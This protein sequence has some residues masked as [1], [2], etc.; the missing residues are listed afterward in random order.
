MS[1]ADEAGAAPGRLP[2]TGRSGYDALMSTFQPQPFGKYVLVDHIATGG[3]A[4]IFKAKSYSHGGFES[5]LVIKRI[6]PHIG[7]KADFVE[8]FIDEAKI[9]VALQHPNIVRIF[10]FGKLAV[11]DAGGRLLDHYFIAME[12][13]EGK[14]V[15]QLLRQNARR[16]GYIPDRFAAYIALETCKGLHYAHTKCDLD[17][18]PYGVVHRDIS[19]SNVLLSYEGE[20]KVA[21]F[22]IA[23]AESNAYETRD[24][25]LKGKFEYMSPEQAT[26][27]EV[28]GRSDVFSLGIVLYEVL[29]SRRLF[30]TDS[31]LE[32]LKLIRDQDV[33]PPSRLRA[34]VSPQLEAIALRALQRDRNQRYPSAQ[35]MADDLREYLFPATNDQLKAELAA[36]LQEMF[37]AEIVAERARLRVAAGV[38]ASLRDRTSGEWDGNTQ[39][40]L[41]QGAKT[42]VTLVVPTVAGGAMVAALLL[43]VGGAGLWWFRDDL[44]AAVAPVATTGGIDALVVPDAVF[45]V[46]G[47]ERGRGA[48]LSVE[49]LSPG[50]HA[51][52]FEAEGHIGVQR[53]VIVA[54]GE[55]VRLTERLEPV[56]A[57]PTDPVAGGQA[58]GGQPSQPAGGQPAGGQ[59]AAPNTAGNP[60]G[61]Q[62]DADEP[63]RLVLRS[64]PEGAEVFVDGRSVGTSPARFVAEPGKRY[65][66]EMRLEGHQTA[67]ASVSPLEP[68]E[69]ETVSLTLAAAAAPGKLTVALTGGGWAHVYV[70]GEKLAKTAPLRDVELAPGSHEIRVVN[71]ALGLDHTESVVVAAGQ[72]A[73]VRAAPK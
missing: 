13:V 31:D 61:T 72:V 14:D 51:V 59:P 2:A 32:T 24:G 9:S 39:S 67:T 22:G 47:E 70:D 64:S 37:A 40:S 60:D 69:Q 65:A 12:C 73:T 28:D 16:G 63:P 21:D 44:A 7:E 30:K 57:Q 49:G 18:Q 46:D 10:D 42:A 4:E 6:L 19:P 1:P 43:A 3:M 11:P 38:A 58:A 56:D 54:A 36:Y 23:K 62:A 68:G 35:A 27:D 5:L 45:F 52:G 48:S 29:T 26:G 25:V 55:V 50:P 66:V 41:S 53:T 34:D 20:V 8:M 15:R 71:E 17:G 33:T